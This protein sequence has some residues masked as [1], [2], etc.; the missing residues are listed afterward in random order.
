M[1]RRL[2]DSLNDHRARVF[3]APYLLVALNFDGILAP[4]VDNPALACVYPGMD[5]LLQA[6][7]SRP[8]TGVAIFSGRERADLQARIRIPGL[9]YAGNHGLEISGPGVLFVEPVAAAHRDALQELST[10]LATRLQSIP[11]VWV[12]DKGLSLSVHYGQ[13]A[14][15]DWE[16][17]RRVVN[18]V[19][20]GSNHPPQLTQGEKAFEIRPRLYWNKGAATLWL[21]EPLGHADALVIYLGGDVTDEDAFKALSDHVTV[22]VG[23]PAETAAQF[24]LESPAEVEEFLRWLS[25]LVPVP[26]THLA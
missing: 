19:L 4:V 16:E 25:S 26:A 6:L 22:R 11:G 15:A 24:Y 12:E 5:Q 17:V 21:R 1:S 7:A 8:E 20:A 10:A 14:E 23:P 2:L 9:I 3:A 18:S 13:A